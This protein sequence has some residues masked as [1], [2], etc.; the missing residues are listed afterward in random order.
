MTRLVSLVPLVVVCALVPARA[1]EAP[2]AAPL[3]LVDGKPV[4]AVV[5]GDPIYLAELESEIGRLHS[6]HGT[7]QKAMHH[8]NPTAVLDRMITAK[9]IS[10]EAEHTGMG[11]LPEVKAF[12]D[13]QKLEAI[14]NYLLAQEITKAG[15]PSPGDV[16]KAFQGLVREYRVRSFLIPHEADAKELEKA[17][18]AGGDFDRLAM[19]LVVK[20]RATEGNQHEWLKSDDVQPAIKKLFDMLKIGQVGPLVTIGQ[21]YTMFRMLEVRYPE[22]KEARE[23]ARSI[24]TEDK[25]GAIVEAYAAKLRKRYATVDAAMLRSLDFEKP[26]AF[27]KLLKDTRPV[28]RVACGVTVTVSELAASME[29]KFYHGVEKAVSGKKVNREKE[30][31]LDNVLNKKVVV[32]EAAAQKLESNPAFKAR[33]ARLREGALFNVYVQK[34]IG[35]DIKVQDS[36]IKAYYDAHRAELM[37]SEVWKLDSIA[38]KEKKGAEEALT[39]L[40]RGADLAWMKSHAPGLADKE[41][42]QAAFDPGDEVA[43]DGLP[44]PVQRALQGARAGDFRLYA[45]D[46]GPYFVLI[47]KSKDEAKQ[48]P[49]EMVYEGIKRKVTSEKIGKAIEDLGA[50]LRAASK[51]T[52]HAT[53]DALTK[54]VM[55]DLAGS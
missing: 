1:V 26:G 36:E 46:G 6:G 4:V 53:G 28:A 17:V 34:A 14:R 8:Q 41:A 22:N 20:K 47:V 38:F 25:Q 52:V 7:D 13:K 44:E 37:G 11:A 15:P 5:G 27:D 40:Q 43:A 50:K 16:E 55:R 33:L 12:V 18:K 39:K 32:C 29:E 31:V 51:V 19:D 30:A 35:P 42:A 9:L 10:L 3:P 48:V 2:K 24:A 45:P 49:L 23:R 54:L 21:S